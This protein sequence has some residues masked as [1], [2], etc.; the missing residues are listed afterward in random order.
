MLIAV[1]FDGTCVEFD[2][3]RIGKDRQYAVTALKLLVEAGHELV[4]WTCRED[5]P[6]N[7]N[8]RYL[9]DAVNWFGDR[10]IPLAGVNSVPEGKDPFEEYTQF[11]GPRMF[12]KLC[13]DVYIDD[14]N[15]GNDGEVDWT[16]VV[17]KLVSLDAVKKL[18]RE[19]LDAETIRG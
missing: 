11:T 3:P 4:L 1:D 12:R 19:E 7:I 16:Q 10:G 5:H 8:K 18:W 2:F 13:A 9:T 14:K 17:W 15:F 6:T